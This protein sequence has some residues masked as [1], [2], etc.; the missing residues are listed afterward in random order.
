VT[1]PFLDLRPA[2]EEMRK[3]LSDAV[4]RVV[5]SSNYVLGPEVDAF[6]REFAAF[7]GAR[8]CVGVGNGMEAIELALRALGIGPGDEVVTVSHTAFPTVAAISATGATPVFVDVDADT[9]CMSPAA[10][11]EGVTDRTRAVLPVHLYGR[12]ADMGPICAVAAD[13]GVPVIEDAAQA[14]GASYGGRLAGTFGAAA[15]FSFYPTKNLG[16]LG[17][18]GAVI[19]DDEDLALHVRRLRNYGE[20]SKYVN[21]TPGFNSR[22]DELQA[23]ILRVKLPHL[24][25]WNAARRAIAARYDELLTDSEVVLP[26]PDDGHAYHLYVVRSRSRE[27]LRRH[28]KSAG[29]GSQVHYPTPVHRQEAYREGARTAGSLAATEQLSGEILSLPAFPGLKDAQVAEVAS[30]VRAF[31]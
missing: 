31:S 1:V 8:H 15:A 23:A 21:V 3:A 22:L 5:D 24:E 28:L 7:C 29:I 25:R 17:D 16:A 27:A 30:A 4:Q 26:Q 13:A 9:F 12:C 2:H 18:G 6:E 11:A 14:H 20:Q 10:L 19:T